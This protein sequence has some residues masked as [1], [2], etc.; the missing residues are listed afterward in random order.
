MGRKIPKRPCPV[1]C[2]EMPATI[3]IRM[4][5]DVYYD[6]DG[7]IS[8]GGCGYQGWVQ[9]KVAGYWVYMWVQFCAN[10]YSDAQGG[11]FYAEPEWEPKF[12][13][14]G[15]MCEGFTYFEEFYGYYI[16]VTV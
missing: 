10:E 7:D 4:Y 13:G 9:D 15:A 16:E 3:H 12:F 11:W 2:D 6:Y 5:W 8:G 1:C 14:Y